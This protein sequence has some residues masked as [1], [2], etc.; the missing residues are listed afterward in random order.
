MRVCVRHENDINRVASEK[1]TCAAYTQKSIYDYCHDII[2]FLKCSIHVH[3]YIRQSKCHCM[4]IIITATNVQNIRLWAIKLNG[5]YYIQ[6]EKKTYVH[7]ICD[8]LFGA[9]HTHTHSVRHMGEIQYN[10]L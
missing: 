8:T 5:Y 7:Y 10:D 2:P 4:C 1:T 9:S 3:A 6:Y